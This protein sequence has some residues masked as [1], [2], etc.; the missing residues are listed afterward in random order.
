MPG[1][2]VSCGKVELYQANREAWQLYLSYPSLIRTGLDGSYVD[3]Q[4]ALQLLGRACHPQPELMLR[5]LEAIR[6]GFTCK[7]TRSK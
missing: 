5:K 7:K 3:Y 6:Q 4:S 1:T 2:C